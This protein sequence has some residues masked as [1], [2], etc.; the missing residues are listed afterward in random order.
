MS[1]DKGRLLFTGR[2]QR[3]E[4]Y[5][6]Y[7][8]YYD[9]SYEGGGREWVGYYRTKVGAIVCAWINVYILSWGGTARLWSKCYDDPKTGM[10]TKAE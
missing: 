7:H 2:P 6:P 3:D 5:R 1:D 9:L 10:P 4:S 8:V